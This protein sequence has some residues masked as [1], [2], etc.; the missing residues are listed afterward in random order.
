MNVSLTPWL[1]EFHAV[2]F[3]GSSA[4]LLCLNGLLSFF[5]LCKEAKHF[6]LRL[7]LC[8]NS[9]SITH[10][11]SI[12]RY[13]SSSDTPMMRMLVHLKLSQRLLIPSLFFGMLFLFVCSS[14]WVFSATFSFKSLT[15]SSA[16]LTL[17]SIPCNVSFKIFCFEERGRHGEREREREKHQCERETSIGWLPIRA[18]TGIEP[19]T[20][21]CALTGNQTH[22]HLVYGIPIGAPTHWAT[23]A[24]AVFLISGKVVFISN[25]FFF[26]FSSLVFVSYLFF[27]NN[28]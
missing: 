21:V 26:V 8:W 1:S 11:F 6:Y 5:W 24:R 22:H 12:L 18:L 9:K 25:L 19:T 2:W 10:R 27:K 23:P 7:H 17:L 4:C 28:F 3:S 13:L 15:W 14:D 20:C 16:S